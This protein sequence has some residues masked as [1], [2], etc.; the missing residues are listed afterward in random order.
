MR[1]MYIHLGLFPPEMFA[2]TEMAMHSLCRSLVANGHQ[3]AVVALSATLEAGQANIDRRCGYPVA[4]SKSLLSAARELTAR[5]PPDVFVV[6]HGGEWL[7]KLA[8]ILGGAPLVIYEHEV[9]DSVGL[10]PEPL[11]SSAAFVANSEVTAAFMAKTY[12]IPST[13][14]RPLFGVDQYAGLERTGDKVLF[15]SLQRRKGADVAIAIARARPKSEFIFVESWTRDA[16]ATQTL[17]DEVAGLANVTLLAN[18]SG[19]ARILPEV[20]LLLMPSRSEESWGRT[21]TE[22]QICGV[23]VLASSRGNLTRTVGPGGFTLDPD[24]PIERWL[25]AFD[26]IMD[27]PA[28]HAELSA[29]AKAHGGGFASAV[30]REYQAF[31]RV[32]AGAVA[33]RAA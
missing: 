11:R 1:I 21:A 27:D 28:H 20:K 29:R 14:V 26:A 2:G 16:A 12:A 4:R 9:A 5:S 6:S 31:E 15:V 30:A 10:I 17:R 25:A 8:P 18:Q 32:L 13:I 3:V 22:A 23:P 33:G 7:E 24:E 19:L